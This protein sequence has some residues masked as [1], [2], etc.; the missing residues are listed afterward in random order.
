[1]KSRKKETTGVERSGG[2]L[3]RIAVFCL[4][5]FCSATN[6]ALYAISNEVVHLSLGGSYFY[7]TQSNT[8]TVTGTV[9]DKEGEP[10][11]GA[12]ILVRG[13]EG[14]GA[15][16]DLDGQFRITGVPVGSVLEVSF[17]G[18]VTQEVRVES[19]S[20]LRITLLEDSEILDEVVVIGYGTQKKVNLTGSVATVDVEDLNNR[21]N[22]NV[23][24]SLQGAIPGVT[25]IN[26]PGSAPSINFR[27]RGNLGTSSPLYVIDGTISTASEF[28]NLDPNV[29]ESISFLKDASSASIYGSRAAY[30][31][32]LVTT[33]GG[34]AGKVRVSYSGLV[35][36][37]NPTYVP[38]T[39]NSA[40]YARLS[41]EAIKNSNPSANPMYT[42]EQIGWFEDGSKPDEYGNSNWFD[43]L[44]GRNVPTT[45]H[46]ASVSGGDAVRYY[47]SVGY[48]NDKHFLPGRGL[49]RFNT[50]AN[51]NADVTDWLRIRG[52]LRGVQRDN[53][54]KLGT[55]G[56]TNMINIPST[57]VARHSDGS[58]GTLDGGKEASKTSMIF[59]PLRQVYDGSWSTSRW[60]SIT[61]DMG[62]D[63]MPL[64]GLRI[65]GDMSYTFQDENSKSFKAQRPNLVNFLTKE[66]ISGTGR[67]ATDSQMSINTYD[68]DHFVTN[69]I[70]NYSKVFS[71]VH[72]FSILAGLSYEDINWHRTYGHRKNFPNN[73]L[74][75]I[76]SGSTA[77][78][79]MYFGGTSNNENGMSQTKLFSVFGRI[80]YAYDNR[81]LL[82]FNLRSDAS[83]R[84]HPDNRVAI[85]P[86]GS[87]GWRVSQED[88]MKE[89]E[90]I[91]DLK[92]RASYGTLGNINNVGDYDYQPTYGQSG[93]YIFDDKV[94]E[95]YAES[96]PANRNL[97]W[98]KVSI[99]DIG[100]DASF[101][102][103]KLSMVLDYYHKHTRD[104][105]LTPNIPKEIGL[106]SL[107]SQNLGEVL[108]KGV[109]LALTWQD[110]VDEF[111]YSISGNVSYNKNEIL[112]LGDSDPI[113]EDVWIKKVGKPIGEFYTYKTDGLLSEEDIKKGNYITDGI[114][115]KPGDIKYVDL[116]GN[117]R[118]DGEDRTY[119]GNDVPFLTYGMN[120]YLACRGF[121]LSLTGQGVLGTK[122][123]FQAEMAHAFFD[124]ANPREWHLGRWTTE[125][126]NVNAV[127]PRIY[128][129]TDAHA[130]FNQYASDFWLFNSDYFRIKNIT[131]GYAVPTSV[132]Q[133]LG[134]N[135]LKVYLSLENFFTIRGDK[136]MLDFDPE[137]S[138][139]RAVSALGEKTLSVGVNL[140][141]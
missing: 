101:F 122:V 97:S 13:L 60:R 69:L 10:I 62:L 91:Y 136:R 127:Y 47:A 48:V 25:I 79:N 35:G 109:E 104:I 115:P 86:S 20:P 71:N 76:A 40:D 125:N 103:N 8:V 29:I 131:L 6:I 96:K 107:P 121:D 102:Q 111:S 140:S 4:L 85:F 59:N 124:H 26:R 78:E 30:G 88:F 133:S 7:E 51:F 126:P 116:N 15:A 61:V 21:A 49:Q 66:V 117:G 118:L 54:R 44:F 45:Q 28:S 11:I 43:M 94:S 129:R 41:N 58:F 132:I 73:E 2:Q 108:N 19:A 33:K 36:F 1:M 17:V 89:V 32:V 9:L 80:N 123:N 24:T 74:K 81:Y 105:L 50:N 98:E 22:T 57:F 83:S 106:S 65:S 72:D 92:L 82:E 139:G 137:A 110:H 37:K 55:P 56:Y 99:F 138:T 12:T 42:D 134:V 112:N 135:N 114:E 75:D 128:E 14:N 119:T 77:P 67:A 120:I 95:G 90:W 18:M 63:L 68:R 52:G 16:T 84:F 130:K 46:S 113:I 100:F 38:R 3:M 5:L 70:A 64:D 31:V 93:F 23:L 53:T 141:F 87:L 34:E 27:G 39:V